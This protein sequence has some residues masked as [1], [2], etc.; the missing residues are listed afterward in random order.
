MY[1]C[2]DSSTM[3]KRKSESD[4]ESLVLSDI[5]EALPKVKVQCQYFQSLSTLAQSRKT[6]S[7]LIVVFFQLIRAMAF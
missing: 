4:N 3:A 7:L 5:L 1:A 6:L 2:S